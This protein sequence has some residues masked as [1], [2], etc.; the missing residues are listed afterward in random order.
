MGLLDFGPTREYPEVI[1]LSRARKTRDAVERVAVDRGPVDHLSVERKSVDQSRRE[2]LLQ[3]CRG[4]SAALIP[5]GLRGFLPNYRFDSRD[6]LL[7]DGGFHVHPHY[8]ADMPLDATLL[9]T[10]SGLDAFVTE[11]YQDQIAKVFAEWNLGLLKS[12]QDMQAVERVLTSDFS[13]SSFRP[14]ESRLVRSGGA[15]EIRQNKFAL[16][17][18]LGRDVFLQ[19]LRSAMNAF[20]KV[21]TAEFQVVGIEMVSGSPLVARVKTDGKDAVGTAGADAGATGIQLRTRVRYELVGSGRDFYREQRVGHWELEWGATSAGEFRLRK[22][23]ALD[24]TW[25]RAAEPV[26][27]DIA[28][29]AFGSNAS[30]SSQLLRGAD[31]WR[32]VL[33]GASGI[34]IYGHNGVSVGD[35][36]GDGFDDLYVCQPAGLPN[37]LYRNRGDGTFEDITET[38]GVGILEN[39]ACALFADF[40]ND[41]RQDLIVVRTSGPL[42]FLNEGGGKFRQKPDAFRVRQPA[43]RDVHGCSRRRL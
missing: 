15:I 41:G 36:D 2:F 37:R 7:S 32:T 17:T 20:S 30:Y 13:A 31:Y 38:S 40:D 19:D 8:R 25:S 39:T 42:L 27:L 35:I 28:A 11:K 4:A 6:S 9:K 34:D 18:A 29:Q 43:A 24:E 26:Y 12:P 1:A 16:P 3:C 23:Q 10:Q 21:L 14:V 22:W 5:A 33:D